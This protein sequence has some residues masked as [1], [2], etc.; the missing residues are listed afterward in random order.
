MDRLGARV[1]VV[2]DAEPSAQCFGRLLK[3]YGY[4]SCTFSQPKEAVEAF[5]KAP[6]QIAVVNLRM[7]ELSDGIDTI[8]A[9][10]QI[11]PKTRIIVTTAYPEHHALAEALSAGATDLIVLPCKQEE[12]IAAVDRGNPIADFLK[13]W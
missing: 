8:R 2:D 9:V 10:K 11:D 4:R 1:L 6:C 3:D 12:L 5:R 13:S 7:P